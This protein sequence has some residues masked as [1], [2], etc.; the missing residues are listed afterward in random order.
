MQRLTR[1]T[2]VQRLKIPVSWTIFPTQNS[3]QRKQCCDLDFFRSIYAV[4]NINRAHERNGL[5]NTSGRRPGRVDVDG[6]Q[7]DAKSVGPKVSR[8]ERMDSHLLKALQELEEFLD[9]F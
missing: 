6:G 8:S 7:D 1:S 9:L 3:C 2:V 4:G 5:E